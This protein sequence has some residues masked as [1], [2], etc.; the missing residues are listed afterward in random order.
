MRVIICRGVLLA[1]TLTF[2]GAGGAYATVPRISEV[3]TAY[4]RVGAPVSINILGTSLCL[5]TPCVAPIV[6]LGGKPIALSA[7]STTSI[8]A[9]LPQPVTLGDY[10]LNVSTSVGSTGFELTL[11]NLAP[12]GL[13]GAKPIVVVD[14]NGQLVGPYVVV[15]NTVGAGGIGSTYFEGVFIRTPT[16][17]FTAPFSN[18]SL[19]SPSA[20][21]YFT[22]TDC[23]GAGYAQSNNSGAGAPSA[24]LFATIIATTAYVWN[25]GGYTGISSNSQLTN[26]GCNTYGVQSAGGVPVIATF[27]LSTLGFVP[28]FSV[29]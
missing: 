6:S 26:Q 16:V 21:V 2:L 9:N 28:P 20:T 13:P 24:M 7:F 25:A 18:N 15:S 8:T 29:Q 17:S 4:S 19:G 10:K 12:L 23:S 5:G 27:D 14:S 3:L 1:L 11:A 22:S